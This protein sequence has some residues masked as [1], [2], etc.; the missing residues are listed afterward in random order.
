[1]SVACSQRVAPDL[2]PA[3]R[4]PVRGAPEAGRA[5]GPLPPTAP[6]RFAPMPRLPAKWGRAPS[7]TR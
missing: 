5:A 7:G 1:M 3:G 6:F 4:G 2:R